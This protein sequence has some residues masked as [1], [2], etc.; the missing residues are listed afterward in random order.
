M[1]VRAAEWQEEAE[2]ISQLDTTYACDR[3]YQVVQNDGGFSLREQA[4]DPPVER[5]HDVSELGESD[6]LFV[7]EVGGDLAGAAGV[8]LSSW[9]RRA[10]VTGL[11][12]SPGFRGRGI[13]AALVE[14]LAARAREAKTHTLWLETQNTNYPAVQFYRRVGFRLCGLDDCF[15]DPRRNPGD[16]ALFFALDL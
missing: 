15:Y 12:V 9:N 7:A 8:A 14:A 6:A 11:Y 3:I 2:R 16:V 10:T 1:N 5:S 13:G 4:V